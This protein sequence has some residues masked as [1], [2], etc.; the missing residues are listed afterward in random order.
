MNYSGLGT[1]KQKNKKYGT[2]SK[3][4]AKSMAYI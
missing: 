1:I 4:K 2:R 3:N